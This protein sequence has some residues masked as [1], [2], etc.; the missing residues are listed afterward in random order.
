MQRAQA[1]YNTR[2]RL[3]RALSVWMVLTLLG[4]W[5]RP[6]PAARA[7]PLQPAPASQVSAYD[8]I[9]AMNTLR[10]AHGNPPLIE[11]PIINAVAQ[12]TAQVMAEQ[13]MSWHI[14]NVRGRLA[15]AGYGGG[16]TVVGNR[17]LR[18]WPLDDH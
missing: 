8:L 9:V 6:L 14:G 13:Q 18:R 2:M 10:V 12:Y 7:I 11:D 1:G 4:G 5:V 16:A 17:K 3:L 15:A